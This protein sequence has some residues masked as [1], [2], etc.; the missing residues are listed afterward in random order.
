MRVLILALLFTSPTT[1]HDFRAD[2]IRAHMQFLASDMLEG[3][4]TGTRGYRIAAEYVAAQYALSGLEPGANGSWYQEV[5]FRKTTPGDDGSITIARS[6]A[7]PVRF[8][9]FDTFISQGDPL[10]ADRTVDGE[11]VFAG[12]GVS[13]PDQRYDDYR[14]VD[15]RGKIVAIFSG[16]PQRFPNAVRAHHSSTAT[17]IETVAQQGAKGLIF[18]TSPRDAQRMPWARNVRQ[19]RLGSMY[20]LRADGT[21]HAVY[22]EVSHSV[23]LSLDATR[24]FL[25]TEADEIF[26]A[27]ERGDPHPHTLPVR[28]TIRLTSR[29]ETVN[30]PNVVGIIRGSDPKLRDEYIVYSSHLDHLGITVAV[31][32]D[33][34]NNGALDNASGVATILEIARNIAALPHKPKRSILFLA[35]TGEEKGLRGADYFAN[36]PTVPQDALAGVINLDMIMLTHRTR[37]VLALG[38]ETNDLGDLARDA[39]SAMR[40]ELSPDPFP[41]EVFFVR[42]DQYPFVRRGIPAIYLDSGYKAVDP[43]I[44]M[45]HEMEEWM[46]MRYHSPKDDLDQKLDYSAALPVA[47]LAYRLGV[48]AAERTQRPRWKTGD[49]FGETFG[50][51]R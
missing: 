4:G 12:F 17:K 27:I 21:P 29:H 20:W 25:G 35:T 6:G 34:I 16:A 32:G 42:S 51:K 1:P 7:T 44:N 36:N 2:A 26:A 45:Q 9:I 49:F 41:D 46:R 28:A 37:D 47:E 10:H 15:V 8:R 31:D 18:L 40:V 13:A 33:A 5:P 11:V 14:G 39:A 30:S 38:A 3:R 23:T 19:S 43:K 22:P 48:S 24:T 50:K